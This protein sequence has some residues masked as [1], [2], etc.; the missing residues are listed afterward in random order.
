MKKPELKVVQ[1]G[2]QIQVD[3]KNAKQKKCECGCEYFL[4]VVRVYRISAIVSP[5]G[6]ELMVHQPAL[7]CMDCRKILV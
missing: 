5:T 2:Q 7:I 4:P 1:P 3:M 6:Q